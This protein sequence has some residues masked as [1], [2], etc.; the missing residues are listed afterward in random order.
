LRVTR[1]A[2]AG[3]AITAGVVALAASPAFAQE[4]VEA[5]PAEALATAQATAD[6]AIQSGN[7]LWVVL[8]AILVIFMQAGFALVETGFCR[9]KHAAH[10]VSTNFAI[11]GLGFVAFFFVGFPLMF[12]GY[13][14]VLPGY[15]YG[16]SAAP[17]S[18][19]IGSDNW[20]FL[21]KGGWA[22]SW[23]DGSNLPYAGAAAA[24]FLYMVAFMDTVATIPTGSMAERWKWKSFVVW[25]LFCGAIYYP[26]F[27]AW[28]WGGGWL[29]K[30]GNSMSWGNGYVDFAG[31]GVVHAVGG[32]A[33][34]AG[35]IVL[36]PRIGKFAKDGTPRAMP[37]HHI[38][39]AM[40]GTFI[41]LFGWFGFNA[42]STFASSDPQ[43]AVVAVNTA[44]AGAFGAVICMFYVWLRTGKPDPAM[45]AN[46][47]LA[48]LVAIT[49]PCAFVD[50]WAAAVIGCIA[51][52]VVVESVYFWERRVKIDDPVGAIS[53][54]GVCGTLGVLFVGIFA[55]GKYGLDAGGA[56][57]G[58]NGTTT[59]VD[60]DGVAEG[61]TGILYGGNG[62]GQLISQLIGILVI[63]TVIF[64]IAFAFFKI[65]NAITKGGI[66]SDEEDEI[67]GLDLPEMGLLAYPEFGV[68]YGFG[69][70]DTPTEMPTKV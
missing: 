14:Y 46:G 56:G 39:M 65:Q 28:T 67:Q 58:W 29:A 21:W 4:V 51:G 54:H 18:A 7:L 32:V 41:L 70:S 24:F 20:V 43:F 1:L 57:I 12:G 62:G 55:N 44:I 48:G 8:G 5:D 22:G 19:L 16:L 66:R 3:L 50:P 47:M 17:G 9:A 30:L 60:A 27:G 2:T 53:V 26:L 64:G 23:F 11:F 25:G 33:A 40:L 38:P 36:G 10:V 37:G 63:W 34:L 49:A 68:G 59:S 45:M 52:L 35:A 13:S 42:A 61:V 6:H 31:S 69:S 15:D